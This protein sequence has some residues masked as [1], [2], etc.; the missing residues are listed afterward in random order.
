M[1]LVIS[2]YD[3]AET[4][5]WLEENHWTMP[6]LCDGREVIERYGILNEEA[7]GNADHAGIPH[8]TT[9]I[10]DSAGVIRFKNIWVN[11]RERTPP[12]A[13]LALLEDIND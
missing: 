3:A 13:M 1:V 11:Y 5:S 2:K 9:L 10:I 12:S 6:L 7:L 8:P 4:A